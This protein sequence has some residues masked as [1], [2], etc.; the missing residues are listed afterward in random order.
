MRRAVCGA[1]SGKDDDCYG[2]VVF[3]FGKVKFTS[4][5]NEG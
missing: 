4:R 1:C 3:S 2:N 5:V